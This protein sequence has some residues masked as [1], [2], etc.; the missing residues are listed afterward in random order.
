MKVMFC[1]RCNAEMPMLDE[2][3][4]QQVS[5]A[6]GRCMEMAKRSQGQNKEALADVKLAEIFK[7]VCETYAKLPGVP[8]DNANAVM[9][10]RISRYGPACKK[11]G[12]PFRTPEARFC[13]ACG[14]RPN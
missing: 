13:A 2:V 3:E 9:H 12:K 7:P 14:W 8:I 6:Y 10:H 1:W 4:Y 5:D 11:C